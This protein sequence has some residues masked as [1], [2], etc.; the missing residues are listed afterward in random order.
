[1]LVSTIRGSP[2]SKLPK[3]LAAKMTGFFEA[4]IITGKDFRAEFDKFDE[5]FT[6]AI[7]Q[8]EFRD[9]LQERLRAALVSREL[10]ALEA[11]YRDPDDPKKI[12]FVRLL[13]DLH[14]RH[15]GRSPSEYD[16]GDEDTIWEMAEKLRQKVRRRCDYTA[17]G[18]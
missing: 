12:S 1:M 16:G 18:D 6:N 11:A 14:P 5:R 2:S 7:T 8:A 17:P 10:E 3:E 13:H 15:S 9:V 4:L